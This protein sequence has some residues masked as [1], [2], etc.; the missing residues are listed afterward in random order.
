MFLENRG[1]KSE[2]TGKLFYGESYRSRKY[3][4]CAPKWSRVYKSMVHS[5]FIKIC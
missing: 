2:L 4:I 3:H 1:F 5:Q